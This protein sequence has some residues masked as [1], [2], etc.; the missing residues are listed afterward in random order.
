MRRKH[1]AIYIII[2]LCLVALLSGCQK[3]QF[4]KNVVSFSPEVTKNLTSSFEYKFNG[5]FNMT[6]DF[7]LQ[8]GDVDWQLED[9]KGNIVFKGNLHND[10]G[11]TV[12][13]LTAPEELSATSEFSEAV[14]SNGPDFYN[15][16]Y[17]GKESGD[18]VL[19]MSPTKAKGYALIIFDDVK[20][21][22]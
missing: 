14:I 9:P 21:N 19:R 17:F 20:T 12:R 13:K 11:K 2:T 4:E 16:Q 22:K 18:F 7:E 10:G 5:Y 1:K 8:A 3:V 6:L 15:L